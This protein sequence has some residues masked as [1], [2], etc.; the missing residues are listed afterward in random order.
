MSRNVRSTLRFH[1]GI[2]AL[3]HLWFRTHSIG[4]VFSYFFAGS[5]FYLW[6]DVIPK[7]KV[8][9]VLALLGTI[10]SFNFD[11]AEPAL[12]TLGT[13]CLFAGALSMAAVLR[14]RGKRV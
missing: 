7:S 1:I 14:V 6:R 5:A 2:M 9:A 11:L 10:A 12:I 13:Y 4:R 8:L 3:Q